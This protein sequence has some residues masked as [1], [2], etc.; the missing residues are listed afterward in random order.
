M[1]LLIRTGEVDG[2]A[3]MA[4]G[5]LI[6]VTGQSVRLWAVRHIGTISRTRTTRYGPLMTA[7]PY[8]I[9]RNPLYVGNWLLWTGFAVWSRLLWMLPVAWMVFFVQYRAIAKWEAGFIRSKYLT[10]Y[11]EYARRVRA[12]MPRWPPPSDLA[13]VAPLHPWREVF[14]SERSTLLAVALMSLLLTIKQLAFE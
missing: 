10:T 7:G 5:A 2:R 14:F 12:W 4:A 3:L 6:V 8:A 9:V 13:A 11:D 1:L